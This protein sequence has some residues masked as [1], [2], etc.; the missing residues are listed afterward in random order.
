MSAKRQMTKSVNGINTLLCIGRHS[1]I[2][3][4]LFPGEG[5][6]VVL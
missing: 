5:M 4:E 1:S 2:R 6:K 3:V